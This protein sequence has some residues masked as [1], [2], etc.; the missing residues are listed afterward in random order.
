MAKCIYCI[1]SGESC[2]HCGR[3][4]CLYPGSNPGRKRKGFKLSPEWDRDCPYYKQKEGKVI[5]SGI[6][7]KGHKVVREVMP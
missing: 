5:Q 4:A 7:E 1:Y 2:D 3:V 6:C